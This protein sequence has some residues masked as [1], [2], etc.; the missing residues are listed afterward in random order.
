MENLQISWSSPKTPAPRLRNLDIT[1]A[2]APDTGGLEMKQTHAVIALLTAASLAACSD[3]STVGAS[4][5]T[6][7]AT[8]SQPTIVSIAPT[9]GSTYGGTRVAVTGSFENNATASVGGGPVNQGYDPRTR[10]TV[11]YVDSPPHAVGSVDV[12][13]SNPGGRSQTL[14]AAFS[15]LDPS[16]FDF[17]GSW[18][19][20]TNDGSDTWI[21]FT[22]T[23][24]V[25]T[26]VQCVP[27]VG[28]ALDVEMSAPIVNG[29][30]DYVGPQGSFSGWVASASEAAGRIDMAPCSVHPWQAD[31]Q[32]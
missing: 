6:P 18:A 21:E 28:T 32:Q 14:V 9:S 15:Y 23:N 13:V 2:V 1:R 31:R 24:Q 26:K 25:L 8:G 19:G 22:V 29:R 5:N 20:F 4:L 3:L 27:P 12:I 7:P 11:L 17:N 10:N 16:A 30:V